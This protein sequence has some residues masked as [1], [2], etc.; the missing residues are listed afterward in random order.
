[1]KA[2]VCARYGPPEVLRVEDV[3]MPVPRRNQVLIR[4]AATAVTS[5]DCYVR[6]LNLPAD[7]TSPASTMPRMRRRGPVR[8]SASL[9]ATR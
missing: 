1:M 7:S 9:A 4:V 8:P 2:V 3:Q 5:S 6:G